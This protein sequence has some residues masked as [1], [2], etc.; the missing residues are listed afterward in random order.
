MCVLSRLRFPCVDSQSELCPWDIAVTVPVNLVAVASGEL[1]DQVSEGEGRGGRQEE[2][3]ENDVCLCVCV[4]VCVCGWVGGWVCVGVG[5]QVCTYIRG[6]KPMASLRVFD[7]HSCP[8]VLG[9]LQS[10]SP[11]SMAAYGLL[12]CGVWLVVYAHQ[13]YIL[14]LFPPRALFLYSE[15]AKALVFKTIERTG[16]HATYGE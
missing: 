16:L 1:T 13:E 15:G 8:A 3:G 9:L 5:V 14:V 10:Q 7:L 4:C 11:C 12:A 6:C 2:E